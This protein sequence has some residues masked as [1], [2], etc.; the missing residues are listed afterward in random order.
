MEFFCHHHIIL[1]KNTFK[2][3]LHYLFSLILFNTIFYL[4]LN[5]MLKIDPKSFTYKNLE[6]FSQKPLSTV[7]NP[8]VA[9]F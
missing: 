7:M 3:S 6:E 2:I 5:F 8:Y 4:K 9:L 1:L